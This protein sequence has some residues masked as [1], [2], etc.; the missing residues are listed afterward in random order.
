MYDY[1]YVDDDGPDAIAGVPF[2]SRKVKF[3]AGTCAKHPAG[4]AYFAYLCSIAV[5][6]L[7]TSCVHGCV[8][9]ARHIPGGLHLLVFCV[10]F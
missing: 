5:I 3:G 10:C 6:H 4:V 2:F 7:V 8:T 1:T 9:P